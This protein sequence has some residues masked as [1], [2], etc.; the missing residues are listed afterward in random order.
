VY[1]DARVSGDA[2]VYGDARVSGDARVYGAARVY[3]DAW[4]SSPLYIQGTRD[5]LTTCSRTEIAVG[6]QVHTVAEW[7]TRYEEIG[8]RYGYTPEQIAEYGRHLRYAAEWLAN[9]P[10]EEVRKKPPR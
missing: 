5:A 7:L 3:G 10:K 1:G 4:V 9:L 6:C 2:R 8:T